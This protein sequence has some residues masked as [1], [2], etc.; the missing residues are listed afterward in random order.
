MKSLTSSVSVPRSAATRCN[1]GMLDPIVPAPRDRPIREVDGAVR[2][3]T[4]SF[5]RLKSPPLKLLATTVRL[6]SS[7]R[8]HPPRVVLAGEHRPAVARKPVGPIGRLQEDADALAGVYFIG[9]CC[10]CR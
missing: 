3:T 10:E 5:G 2:F 1:A 9:G 4:T 6:P 8:R 7:S